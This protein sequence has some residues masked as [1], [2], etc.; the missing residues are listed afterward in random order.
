V[1]KG[2]NIKKY[3]QEMGWGHKKL[4]WLILEQL[5][6]LENMAFSLWAPLNV[7]NFLNSSEAVSDS[8]TALLHR[9]GLCV[10]TVHVSNKSFSLME[11]SRV[12]IVTFVF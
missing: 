3:L 6:R 11:Y 9:F 2:D 7:G 4:T 10:Y 1:Y 12:K 8:R 5:R